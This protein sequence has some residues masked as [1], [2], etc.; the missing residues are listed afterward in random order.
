MSIRHRREK[1]KGRKQSGTFFRIPTA[2]LASPAF[3][4]L[5][6]KAKALLLDLG[7][8]FRGFNNGDITIAFSVMKHRGWVSKETLQNAKNELI[9][10]GMIEK[11]RQ[12]GLHQ[13]DLFGFTW[14]EIHECGGKL[15]AA[16]STTPSNRWRF[17]PP[18]ASELKTPTP[19]TG[20]AHPA[21]RTEKS[22]YRNE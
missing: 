17:A 21:T 15:D 22:E 1:H 20:A 3:I 2:V 4:G 18:Q 11:T 19:A 9:A 14:I 7:E 13:C 12:G 16:P 10:N 8:Q 6:F 5:T